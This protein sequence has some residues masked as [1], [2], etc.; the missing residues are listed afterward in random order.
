VAEKDAEQPEKSPNDTWTSRVHG[1][2]LSPSRTGRVERTEHLAT[3]PIRVKK[4][5]GRQK[6]TR[7]GPSAL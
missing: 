2:S 1:P 6:C 4:K 7:N 3:E 5:F